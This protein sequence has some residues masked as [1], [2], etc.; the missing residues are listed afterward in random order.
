MIAGQFVVVI[1]KSPLSKI[2]KIMVPFFNYGVN[3]RIKH[4]AFEI[5]PQVHENF[6]KNIVGK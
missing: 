6:S 4:F 1:E 5:V 2:T 3:F